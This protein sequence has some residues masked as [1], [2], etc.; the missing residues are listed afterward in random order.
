[1]P[2]NWFFPKNLAKS[3]KY[4][5]FTIT[6]FWCILSLRYVYIFEISTKNHFLTPRSAHFRQ[7]NFP[8]PLGPFWLFC[9]RNPS[10]LKKWLKISKIVFCKHVFNSASQ[11]ESGCYFMN[12]EKKWKIDGGYYLF[13]LWQ[14]PCPL[15][16]GLFR[17]TV[18]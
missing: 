7:K 15:R 13:G 12:F 4:Q 1:M 17:H 8:S 16:S 5:F 2:K 9:Y 10:L 18:H 11:Y 14:V 3:K 6:F